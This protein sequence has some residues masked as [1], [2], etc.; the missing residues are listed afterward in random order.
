[1]IVEMDFKALAVNISQPGAQSLFK[2]VNIRSTSSWSVGR[3]AN[4]PKGGPIPVAASPVV[5]KGNKLGLIF[6]AQDFPMLAKKLFTRLIDDE[7]SFE[8]ISSTGIDFL[9][10]VLVVIFI[11]SHNFFEL[12]LAFSN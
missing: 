8:V 12:F 3:S 11:E 4:E 5:C 2:L 9:L 6:S 7:V 10:I 1:M